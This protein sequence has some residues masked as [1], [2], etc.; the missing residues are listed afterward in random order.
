MQF[1]SDFNT[2]NKSEDPFLSRLSESESDA[3]SDVCDMFASEFR[4]Y[5]DPENNDVLTKPALDRAYRNFLKRQPE[6]ST[7]FR[8]QLLAA[9]MK[10]ELHASYLC[11]GKPVPSAADYASL[12]PKMAAAIEFSYI[13]V[14]PEYRSEVS[15]GGYRVIRPLGVGGEASVVEVAALRGRGT[16]GAL[17]FVRSDDPA[18][19]ERIHREAAIIRHI[20]KAPKNHN[21]IDCGPEEEAE[22]FCYLWMPIVEGVSLADKRSMPVA[23]LGSVGMQI[24]DAITHVHRANCLHLDIH[25]GNIRLTQRWEDEPPIATLIDFGLAK[26]R[27]AGNGSLALVKADN[28]TPFFASPEHSLTKIDDE[29]NERGYLVDDKGAIYVD[30]RSDI[31]GLGKTLAYALLREAVLDRAEFITRLRQLDSVPTL[32]VDAIIKA[33]ESF[34]SKRFESASEFR[35]TLRSIFPEEASRSRSGK[36]IAMVAAVSSLVLA[37][38]AFVLLKRQPSTDEAINSKFESAIESIDEQIKRSVA[39]MNPQPEPTWVERILQDKA[40]SPGEISLDDFAFTYDFSD[41]TRNLYKLGSLDIVLS[42]RV[43]DFASGVELRLGDSPWRSCVKLSDNSVAISFTEEDLLREG[44]INIQID[45]EPGPVVGRTSIGPFSLGHSLKAIH[46]TYLDSEQAQLDRLNMV[47]LD[48][49]A[50][51]TFDGHWRFT[52]EIQP[53]LQDIKGMTIYADEGGHFGEYHLP[54]EQ[55]QDA[56]LA[57]PHQYDRLDRL[58]V[59]LK[60][61]GNKESSKRVFDRRAAFRLETLTAEEKETFPKRLFAYSAKEGWH[62]TEDFYT[63]WERH[64]ESLK[65]SAPPSRG[66]Y[67][68]PETSIPIA[69]NAKTPFGASGGFA[70]TPPFVGT[71]EQLN[72]NLRARGEKF[73]HASV[74]YV[75]ASFVDRSAS[76]RIPLYADGSHGE[77]GNDSRPVP[78]S[79]SSADGG[80]NGVIGP[81]QPS[82]K[83]QL[84]EER[85]LR[86]DRSVIGFGGRG[87]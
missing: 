8:V 56:A 4:H 31:Y 82:P 71:P 77:S 83:A 66:I 46:A 20:Q 43:D 47:D 60:L 48:N 85:K 81:S 44:S 9:L 54:S 28:D 38:V 52:P 45:D 53:Y 19:V 10:E 23:H 3:I 37:L 35:D 67:H 84:N 36:S 42:D 76:L 33:T 74:L 15:I 55:L 12:Y 63:K 61:P 39:S 59:Q 11:L 73:R 50:W 86:E 49:F 16:R 58:Y 17:K 26:N 25:P 18:G 62:F 14:T 5:A 70:K 68:A 65:L 40:I 72:R 29:S 1:D 6:T 78:R 41:S 2:L 64:L 87:P 79:V 30:E 57:L 51:I 7:S 80:S 24:A 75:R 13:F 21:M 34:P 32:F 27:D 69:W 22:G